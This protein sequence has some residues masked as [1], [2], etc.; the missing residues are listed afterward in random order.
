MAESLEFTDHQMLKSILKLVANNNA[1]LRLIEQQIAEIHRYTMN[2][3]ST[4]NNIPQKVVT[5]PMLDEVMN[6]YAAQLEELL[7][8]YEFEVLKE[9]YNWSKEQYL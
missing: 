4:V 9:V 2:T 1:R 7:P 3:D 5:D 6:D 8:E